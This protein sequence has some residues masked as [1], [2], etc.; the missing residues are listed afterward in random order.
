MEQATQTS[1]G[2]AV[3]ETTF[4]APRHHTIRA[5]DGRVI[6]LAGRKNV[7]VIPSYGCN[8]RCKFCVNQAL[9]TSC[10]PVRHE[11]QIAR[12]DALMATLPRGHKITLTGGEVTM[13]PHL[14]DILRVL[15]KHRHDTYVMTN[16]FMLS[17]LVSSKHKPTGLVLSRHHWD[18]EINARMFGRKSVWLTN[19]DMIKWMRR[20]NKIGLNVNLNCVLSRDGLSTEDDVERMLELGKKMGLS[21][22]RFFDVFQCEPEDQSDYAVWARENKVD[23][24]ALTDNLSLDIATM[25]DNEIDLERTSWVDNIHVCFTTQKMCVMDPSTDHTRNDITFNPDGSLCQGAMQSQSVITCGKNLLAAIA[26]NAHPVYPGSATV[27]S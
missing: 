16:G 24:R 20:L 23:V 15:N 2:Y 5:D 3:G 26:E 7:F 25:Y 6:D 14:E 1:S 22:I 13:T 4:T 27:N 8:A 9:H 11:T 12:L 18:E 21:T 10:R 17:R 19:K